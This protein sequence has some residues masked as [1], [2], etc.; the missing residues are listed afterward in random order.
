M[1]PSSSVELARKF[2]NKEFSSGK[3]SFKLPNVLVDHEEIQHSTPTSRSRSEPPKRKRV[4]PAR[5]SLDS[6]SLSIEHSDSGGSSQ[7]KIDGEIESG[8]EDESEG[9]K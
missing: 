5:I 2:S 1:E 7:P 6:P 3:P 4:P 9:K 8:H